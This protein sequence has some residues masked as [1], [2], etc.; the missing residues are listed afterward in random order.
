MVLGR[1]TVGVDKVGV[2]TAELFSL[3]VHLIHKAGDA[4]ANIA[5]DNVAGLVCRLQKCTVKQILHGNDD[6][7]CNAGSA[8]VVLQALKTIVLRNDH[9]VKTHTPGVDC[10][11]CQQHSHDLG[12]ACGGPLGV[13]VVAVEYPP[14]VQIHQHSGLTVELRHLQCQRRRGKHTHHQT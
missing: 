9:L 5:A 4:A 3:S 8:G 12:K 11:Q 7:R 2:L 6:A 10:L 13:H 14:R 1:Q